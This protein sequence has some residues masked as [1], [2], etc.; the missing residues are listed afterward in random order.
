MPVLLLG[1]DQVSATL[2]TPAVALVIVGV[3]GTGDVAVLAQVYDNANVGTTHTLIVSGL[4]I[5]NSS[6]ADVTVYG[7][8]AIRDT[9]RSS[10]GDVSYR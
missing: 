8:P 7:N 6:G 4:T 3:L 9:N 1:C 5:K 10:G 2:P